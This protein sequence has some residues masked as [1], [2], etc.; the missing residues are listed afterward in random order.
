MFKENDRVFVAGLG[1]PGHKRQG[2]FGIVVSVSDKMLMVKS[3][4][5]GR[6]NP[7]WHHHCRLDK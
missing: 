2:Y 6:I 1:T 5:T 7:E 3:H 4:G